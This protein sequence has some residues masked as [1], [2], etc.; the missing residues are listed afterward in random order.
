M[1]DFDEGIDA[2][3]NYCRN[4][5]GVLDGPWCYTTDPD[6]RWEYCDMPYCGLKGKG[7]ER[8]GRG[9]GR[10]RN[11]PWQFSQ[12][13]PSNGLLPPR[14]HMGTNPFKSNFVTRFLKLPLE[15]KR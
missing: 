11:I 5:G 2:A 12:M 4:P 8:E 13:L 9:K 15:M 7:R 10:A 14:I 3:K 1:T 6:T